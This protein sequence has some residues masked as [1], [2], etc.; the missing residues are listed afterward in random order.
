LFS[1]TGSVAKALS[2]LGWEV[3]TLDLNPKAKAQ[4]QINILDWEYW[5][6]PPKHFQLISAGPPCEEYSIAKTVG[7]RDFGKADKL[8]RKT[9]DIIGYFQPQ[10]WWLENPRGGYL[11][12]RGLLDHTPHVDVDYCQFSDWGYR[13]PTRVWGSPQIGKLDHVVC[14]STCPNRD[15]VTSKHFQQLGGYGP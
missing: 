4:L 8:I 2:D 3:V 5:R 11:K 1:G 7:R 12:S 15:P 10:L 9:L 6:L 13:K 14:K